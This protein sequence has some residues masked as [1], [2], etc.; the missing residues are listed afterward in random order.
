M[1]EEF[2]YLGDEK[3]REVVITNPNRVADSCENILPVRLDKC[4]P[5]I[6]GSEEELREDV[7]QESEEYLW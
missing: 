2:S 1:L 5:V 4:P 7:L 3:A 6:E